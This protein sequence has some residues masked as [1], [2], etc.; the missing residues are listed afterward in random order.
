MVGGPGPAHLGGG[1]LCLP[2]VS[3]KTPVPGQEAGE[4]LNLLL[5][6]SCDPPMGCIRIPVQPPV[7]VWLR[8]AG[9]GHPRSE[10]PSVQPVAISL[11][12]RPSANRG[13]GVQAASRASRVLRRRVS[14]SFTT[15]LISFPSSSSWA[16]SGFS[17][18]LP[19]SEGEFALAVRGWGGGGLEGLSAGS[20]S[21]PHSPYVPRL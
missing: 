19:V 15:D 6:P 16:N 3:S 20:C 2:G 10:S 18:R 7:P 5:G 9:S 13:L 12:H 21:S 8:R 17:P 1:S 11:L 4:A 14:V